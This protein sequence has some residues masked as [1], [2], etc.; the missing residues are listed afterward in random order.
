MRIWAIWAVQTA[1]PKDE[2][3]LSLLQLLIVTALIATLAILAIP[4]VL[5][6]RQQSRVV[7]IT[8]TAK[9]IQQAL[10]RAAASINGNY[11]LTAA[12]D[13]THGNT[14]WQGRM[15]IWAIWAVQ[16]V[17]PKDEAWF[18]MPQLL[19]VTA[20]LATL[21]MLAVP[22][23]LALRQQSRV[24]TI[25]ADSSPIRYSGHYL[26]LPRRGDLHAA[27]DRRCA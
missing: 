25:T 13:G 27:S 7:T 23:V 2:V 17:F 5:A 26:Y 14:D 11:P 9:P 12:I 21:A 19:M 6:L 15:R 3:W 16:T 8:A 20:L 4:H 24:V 18:G 10:A 22:R 1:F